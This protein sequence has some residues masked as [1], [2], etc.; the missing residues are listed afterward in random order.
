MLI[1]VFV[2]RPYYLGQA[3][4]NRW[5]YD[6]RRKK[7]DIDVASEQVVGGRGEIVKLPHE[8]VH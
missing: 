8:K 3:R 1:T 6:N 2:T 5:R 4:C 7:Y